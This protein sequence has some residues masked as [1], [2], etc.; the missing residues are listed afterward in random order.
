M[1]KEIERIRIKD[2][3]ERAGVSVGTV[4]RVLHNRSGVS[5]SSKRKVEAILEQLNY[6]PNMYASA[7]ASNKKYRF[8]CLVPQHNAGDYW[9]N[10]LKGMNEAVSVFSDF[11]VSLDIFYYDQYELGAFADAGQKIML[12]SPD[13]VIIAPTIEEETLKLVSQ[14]QANNIPF[15]FID[16]TIPNLS[17][18][19]FYG[20]DAHQSGYFAASILMLLAGG[21]QEIV[22]F[23]Q[24][25]EGRL[26]SNQ[27]RHREEGFYRYINQHYPSLKVLELNLY[28][29]RP[30]D[31]TYLLDE[32]FSKHPYI[33][34][35]ITFNSKAYIIGEYMQSRQKTDFRL[36]GYD[37]LRRNVQCLKQGS[38]QFIIA[39]QPT[40]QGYNSVE[41]LCNHLILKKKVRECNYMPITLLSVDNMDFYLDIHSNTNSQ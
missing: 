25:N 32:F 4:D 29:K 26:G 7:L 38:I 34:C 2:I 22:I 28:A 41:C 11:N 12:N 10:V 18:L 37:M 3:A 13:G 30:N 33:H 8:A 14:L 5:E 20:Q 24:I 35:G 21:E 23:R 31:D 15:I 1:G 17:P 36:I 27:Q 9:E 39:Q 16:S 6:Q 40:V 19:S